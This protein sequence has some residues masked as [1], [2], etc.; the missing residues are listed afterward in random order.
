MA[1]VEW[2]SGNMLYPLPVV[3]VTSRSPEG[4][5]DIMTA[6]WA[7]TICSDPVMVSV[8]VRPSRLTYDYITRSGCFVINLTT[9][10]LAR[11]TD[12]CGVRSGRDEDKFAAMSL[13]KEEARHI[14]CP[15]VKASPVSLEC[16]VTES[17]DL[18]SHTMFMA[19]V[20]AVH[21]DEAY[22][23]E[24]ARLHLNDARLIVYSHGEYR[25]VGDRL[26]TFGFSVEKKKKRTLPHRRR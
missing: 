19:K 20:A 7:G 14:S 24:K 10:A 1:R 25:K 18:G 6:A 22:L 5:D 3:L 15:M 2:K 8:S 9:E 26:G 23:D 17:R 4:E 16:V 13:E 11:A 21:V 12:Y